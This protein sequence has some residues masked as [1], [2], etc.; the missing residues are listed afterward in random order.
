[1]KSAERERAGRREDDDSSIR[2]VE[3]KSNGTMK[4]ITGAVIVLLVGLFGGTILNANAQGVKVDQLVKGL[5]ELKGMLMVN[6]RAINQI[7]VSDAELAGRV[8]A[9]ENGTV[10]ATADRYRR[11]EADKT[12]A[13]LQY[14]FDQSL[15]AMAASN[16]EMAASLKRME[17]LLAESPIRG[18]GG[19]HPLDEKPKKDG[20]TP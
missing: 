16:Q 19:P 10:A 5:G 6:A 13:D 3:I 18:P 15:R 20:G 14:E 12:H 17:A 9:L 11:A 8:S 2:V 7:Q 1:M 4:Q